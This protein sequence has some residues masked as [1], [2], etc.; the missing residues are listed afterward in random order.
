M[1]FRTTLHIE[2][3]VEQVFHLFADPENYQMVATP[4]VRFEQVR[5]TSEGVGTHYF[6]S[7][8]IAGL[9]LRGLNVFTE[10]VPNRRITDTSSNSL[11]G[12]WSYAF[13]ADGS[14]TRLT[15]ENQVGAFWR[16]PLLE[17][18]L[19]RMTARTH[20]PALERIRAQLEQ[21]HDRLTGR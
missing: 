3:P 20:G 13:E 9:T 2:A 18:V 4:G 16:I 6:W 17:Q 12:T 7:V 14:G 5:R 8:R 21:Q 15:V 1:T 10:F 19:D 11:E